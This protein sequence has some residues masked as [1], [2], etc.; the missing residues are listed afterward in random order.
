MKTRFL[1]AALTATAATLTTATGA[2]A[3]SSSASGYVG[4]FTVP[5]LPV[6]VCVN[7]TCQPTPPLKS[8]FMYVTAQ[9]DGP[10]A[11]TITP[12][13]CASGVGGTLVVGAGPA[14]AT[15]VGYVSGTRAD[16]SPYLHF[17]GPVEVAPNS[18]A[19]A[20]ACAST[21]SSASSARSVAG[22]GST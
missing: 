8:F 13:P 6:Q 15:F 12:G 14:G 18:A 9:A 20:T 7:G 22:A 2:L 5:N 19:T 21:S 10:V 11:P 3:E 17:F 4:T 16:G 1:L